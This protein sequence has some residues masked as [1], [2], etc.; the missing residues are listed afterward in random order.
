MKTPLLGA[1]GGT[2]PL[3]TADFLATFTLATPAGRDQEHI[4]LL[5]HGGCVCSAIAA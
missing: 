1:L 3:A 4:P 5:V 2:G